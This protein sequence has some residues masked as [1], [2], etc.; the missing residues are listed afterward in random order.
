LDLLKTDNPKMLA[1]TA[2]IEQ[3]ELGMRVIFESSV[4]FLLQFDP[5]VA[6]KCEG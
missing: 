4:A 3:D 2:V 6:K 5:V 1:G